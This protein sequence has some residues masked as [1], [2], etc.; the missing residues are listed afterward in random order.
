MVNSRY[1]PWLP[2]GSV[3][4][5]TRP[6]SC[7]LGVNFATNGFGVFAAARVLAVAVEADAPNGSV[8][9]PVTSA[10]AAPILNRFRRLSTGPPSAPDVHSVWLV[11]AWLKCSVMAFS[12]M[13]V[14]A[15]PRGR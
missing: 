7:G 11:E 2:S 4:F 5:T 9:P 10:P 8:K 3:P 14:L 13:H 12:S 6:R 15:V 1:C